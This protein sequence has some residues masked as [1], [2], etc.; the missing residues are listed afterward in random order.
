MSDGRVDRLA[1]LIPNH[2]TD[3]GTLDRTLNGVTE[4][5]AEYKRDEEEKCLVDLAMRLEGFT[6][7]SLNPAAGVGSGQR[8][9]ASPVLSY[10]APT[11][12]QPDI[13]EASNMGREG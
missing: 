4:F 2:P 11:S 5:V 12:A 9:L 13:V 10:L 6:R 8:P 3:S 7:H 1:K